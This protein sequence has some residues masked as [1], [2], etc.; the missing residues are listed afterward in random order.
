MYSWRQRDDTT[1]VD[2][3]LY[4]HYLATTSRMH[5][6][7]LEV[8]ASQDN[9]G[10]RVV[11]QVMLGPYRTPVV[12]FKQMAKHLV[13]LDRGFLAQFTNIL[14]TR[15]PA[16]MLNSLQIQLPDAS[17]EDTG[18]IELVEVCESILEVGETPLVVDSG[19]LLADPERVLAELCDLVGVGYDPAMMSWPSGP[20]PEDGVWARHWYHSAHKS[21]GWISPTS[22][23]VELG[24][25]LERV[26]AQTRP[27]YARLQQFAIGS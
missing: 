22:K 15:E 10:S 8:L 18:Y 14:L 16:D 7:A 2:E 24:P 17:L 11:H 19:T 3:P 4:A 26:L 1:V 5:P 21:T 12:F 6:G 25:R 13:E 27:L 9:D 23:P 20:K